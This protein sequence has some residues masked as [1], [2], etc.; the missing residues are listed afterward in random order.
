MDADMWLLLQ[1]LLMV[2]YFQGVKAYTYSCDE[3][4]NRVSTFKLIYLFNL[5]HHSISNAVFF[6]SS[7]PNGLSIRN[8]LA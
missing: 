1:L 7:M 6:R 5:Y 4:Q 3:I 8:T 2:S